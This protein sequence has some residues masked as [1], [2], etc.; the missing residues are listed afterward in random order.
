MALMTKGGRPKRRSNADPR[1]SRC[2]TV[3]F[4]KTFGGRTEIRLF[5]KKQDGDG[6]RWVTAGKAEILKSSSAAS[7]RLGELLESWEAAA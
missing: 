4:Y 6:G 5:H 2:L 3:Y 1:L 7:K